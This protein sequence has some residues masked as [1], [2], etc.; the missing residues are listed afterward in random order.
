VDDREREL[1]SLIEQKQTLE[2]TYTPDYPDVVALSRR[3]AD[4]QAE[5]ANAST[6]PASAPAPLTVP[7]SEV[8]KRRDPPELVQLK[9]KL[10]SVQQSIADTKTEQARIAQKIRIYESKVESSPMVEEEFKQVTRDHDTALQFYNSLL[11]KMNESSMATALEQR[12]QG[13]QFSVMD[14]PNLPDAPTFPNRY[15]FAGGGFIGGML[16]GLLIAAFLEYRNTAL[17]TEKDIWAFTQLPTLAII[18]HIDGLPKPIAAK[19]RWNPFSRS[20]K[21]IQS[22]GG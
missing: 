12:Q 10:R 3:I 2:N 14:A 4:L 1:K 22:A 20:N 18:S 8:A 15:A 16:L 21:L 11:G 17:R 19:S 7:D 13:E 5:I 6:A 9:F